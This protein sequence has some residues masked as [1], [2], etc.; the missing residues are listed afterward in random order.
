MSNQRLSKKDINN[1]VQFCKDV[2]PISPDF[3]ERCCVSSPPIAP[4]IRTYGIF[5]NEILV[6]MMTATYLFVMPCEDS[7]NGRIVHI[8]GA[9]TKPEYRNLG[10]ASELLGC[11]EY[12]AKNFF[13][14]D[15][16]CCDSIANAL[17]INN[18]FI[19]TSNDETRLWK[20]L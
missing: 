5:Q 10:Y 12:D 19:F 18:G 16:L 1:L 3:A 17:Y 6:A 7:P 15:Y 4:C 14:A 13:G 8:S 2:F 20:K 11:I 9:Y